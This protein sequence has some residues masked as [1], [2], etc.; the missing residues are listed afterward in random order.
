MESLVLK[1]S[2]GVLSPLKLSFQ[3]L[4]ALKI[5]LKWLCLAIKTKIHSSTKPIAANVR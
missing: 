3:N 4:I 5:W 1:M 2:K